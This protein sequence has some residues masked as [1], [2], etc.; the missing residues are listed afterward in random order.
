MTAIPTSRNT[1][2]VQVN[3]IDDLRTEAVIVLRAVDHITSDLDHFSKS[4]RNSGYLL[5]TIRTVED[6]LAQARRNCAAATTIAQRLLRR[7]D[8]TR[9][10][11]LEPGNLDRLRD[12]FALLSLADTAYLRAMEI[13]KKK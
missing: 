6:H 7:L 1:S 8:E 11:A 2:P 5:D 12:A 9:S 4:V 10:Q 3:D 13:S